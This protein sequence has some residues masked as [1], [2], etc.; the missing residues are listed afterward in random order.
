MSK[1]RSDNNDTGAANAIDSLMA[2]LSGIMP[3]RAAEF[4][5]KFYIW[6]GGVIE[7]AARRILENCNNAQ[8]DMLSPGDV[9]ITDN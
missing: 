6:S 4:P 2:S 7:A 1:V 3:Q 9:T 5:K 8:V